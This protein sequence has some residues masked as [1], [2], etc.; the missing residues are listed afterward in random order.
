M[1]SSMEP[2]SGIC[3]VKK[4][5]TRQRARHMAEYTSFFIKNPPKKQKR[6]HFPLEEKRYL[7]D[8]HDRLCDNII[9]QIFCALST[10]LQKA[11]LPDRFSFVIT[12]FP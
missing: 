12:P 6:Y 3:P 1:G 8:I 2:I 11:A 5:N 9:I 4:G 10:A 7:L